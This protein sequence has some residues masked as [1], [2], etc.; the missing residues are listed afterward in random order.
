ACSQLPEFR[1]HS[2]E[3]F[4]AW[5]RTILASRLSKLLR[6]HLADRRT[7]QREQQ[8]GDSLAQSSE[9]LVNVAVS[10]GKSPSELVSSQETA[11]LVASAIEDL[12]ED[13]RTIILLRHVQGLPYG[14][15]AAHMNRTENAVKKLWVRALIC[16]RRSVEDVP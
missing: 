6:Y 11:V 4:Q 9:R 10:P 14:D 13:Y 7:P 1:G 2:E 12:P 3:Q 15:V 16:L 8:L 5:L